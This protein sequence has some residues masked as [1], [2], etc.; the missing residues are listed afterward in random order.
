[1]QATQT[2]VFFLD[3]Q[4]QARHEM[5]EG[6]EQLVQALARARARELRAQGLRFVTTATVNVDCASPM[7]V[8]AV[9]DGTLPSGQSYDWTKRRRRVTQRPSP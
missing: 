4:A 2:V 3:A 8:D 1:M 9:Q 5:F 7:G 6:P